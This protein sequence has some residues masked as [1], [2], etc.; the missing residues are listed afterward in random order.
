MHLL[1]A[2]FPVIRCRILATCSSIIEHRHLSFIPW[3]IRREIFIHY[4][5]HMLTSRAEFYVITWHWQ[6][7]T[8]PD[9]Q[10]TTPSLA[11][12]VQITWGQ[13][14]WD[15][16]SDVNTPLYRSS[17]FQ[18]CPHRIWCLA[19]RH[20]AVRYGTVRRMTTH[21][22]CVNTHSVISVFHQS[23]PVP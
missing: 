6:K 2:S 4:C 10:R 5:A 1:C 21:S 8:K 12:A 20:G 9:R 13:V 16:T 7:W 18:A 3:H 19:S 23:A 15:E 17:Q 14:R 11:H 22:R